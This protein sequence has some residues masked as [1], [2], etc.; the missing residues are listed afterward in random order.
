MAQFPTCSRA[1]GR[2]CFAYNEKHC[3]ALNDTNFGHKLCP[4]FKTKKQYNE[5]KEKYDVRYR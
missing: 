4:F 3:I 2:K 1:D 5:D